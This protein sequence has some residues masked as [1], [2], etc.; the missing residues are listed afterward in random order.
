MG[1]RIRVTIDL[2]LTLRLTRKQALMASSD[3]F[4]S[5]LQSVL[6][7][8]S[9]REALIEALDLDIDGLALREP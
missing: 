9:A 5:R 2:R 8:S 4:R 7:H 3:A 6:E 1:R